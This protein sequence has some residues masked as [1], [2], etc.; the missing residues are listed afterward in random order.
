VKIQLLLRR[1]SRFGPE[2]RRKT[3]SNENSF[4]PSLPFPDRK[5][6]PSG[7]SVGSR[8]K[9]ERR[10]KGGR[11]TGYARAKICPPTSRRKKKKLEKGK[12]RDFGAR[13]SKGRGKKKE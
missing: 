4:L 9:K 1:G 6:G 7:P 2:E 11:V 10:R 13:I 5:E 8:E 3:K 12:E